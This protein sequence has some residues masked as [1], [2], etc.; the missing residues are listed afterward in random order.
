M[1]KK[2]EAVVELM[3]QDIGNVLMENI[4]PV[5]VFALQSTQKLDWRR[6]RSSEMRSHGLTA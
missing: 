4:L 3:R 2:Y 1:E 5:P 6:P